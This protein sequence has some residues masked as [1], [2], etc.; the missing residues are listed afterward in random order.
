MTACRAIRGLSAATALSAASAFSLHFAAVADSCPAD[1]DQSGMVTGIDLAILLGEWGSCDGRGQCPAD[2]DASGGVNGFD[3][4]TLLAAWGECPTST[5]P[6][7]TYAPVAHQ[8]DAAA[9]FPAGFNVIYDF[10][11]TPQ[12]DAASNVFFLSFLR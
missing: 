4:A 1:F 10:L 7:I 8:G 6:K 12:I 11:L 5:P 2:L 3:L 9:G